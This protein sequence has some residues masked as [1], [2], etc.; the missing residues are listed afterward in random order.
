[1]QKEMALKSGVRVSLRLQDGTVKE[2]VEV[3]WQGCVVNEWYEEFG[4]RGEVYDLPRFTTSDIESWGMYNG[5]WAPT[6]NDWF[7]RKKLWQVLAY[8]TGELGTSA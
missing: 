2:D 1:M 5:Y 3:D 4:I 7:R 6:W 8:S